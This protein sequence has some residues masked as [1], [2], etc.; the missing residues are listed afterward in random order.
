[1]TRLGETA[2]RL[3]AMESH[4][5]A[6][7]SPFRSPTLSFLSLVLPSFRAR[8]EGKGGGGGGLSGCVRWGCLGAAG[9][10]MVHVCMIISIMQ[11][12]LDRT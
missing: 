6:F 4:F 8:E 1:M 12:E 11:C 9:G 3:S 5:K 10:G 7:P 2:G